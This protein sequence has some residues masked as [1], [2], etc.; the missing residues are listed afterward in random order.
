MEIKYVYASC[1]CEWYDVRWSVGA[2]FL[3]LTL[4][5]ICLDFYP[6]SILFILV[7]FGH[8]KKKIVTWACDT[9]C[10]WYKT[11]LYKYVISH[12]IHIIKQI[13]S[14]YIAITQ[15]LNYLSVSRVGWA[16]NVGHNVLL[17][18]GIL[19]SISEWCTLTYQWPIVTL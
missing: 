12:K 3:V 4:L 10:R 8:S 14:L 18:L 13:K 6:L 15:S 19:G 9:R 7:C 16:R 5:Y 1:C 2:I 17:G 11:L